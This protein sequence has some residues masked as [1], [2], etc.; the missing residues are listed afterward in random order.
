M[1]STDEQSPDGLLEFVERRTEAI[2][3]FCPARVERLELAGPVLNGALGQKNY[4]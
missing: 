4:S 2:G 1:K 3:G